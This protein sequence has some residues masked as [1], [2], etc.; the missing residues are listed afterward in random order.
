MKKAIHVGIT[1]GAGQ[2]CYS[3]LTRI[4][5]G[6]MLG[7]DQPIILHILEVSSAL[8]ALKGLVMELYDCAFPLLEG[9]HCGSDAEAL[10]EEVE[11][12][13]LVGAKPRGKGMERSDL[14]QANAKI[15][16]DQA[17]ALDRKSVKV[18]VVGNPANTNALV[19]YH[20]MKN[21]RP[22]NIRS[23]MRLDQNRAIAQLAI[24]SHV[25][26]K[27]V[28]KVAVFGN[29]SP[30]MVIDYHNA[31][32][33][34]KRGKDV[35]QNIDWL[36]REFMEMVQKRGAAIIE[37]RGSSSAT[38]ASHAVIM[39][40]RDWF[41]E[42]PKDDWYTAG[43]YTKG[44]PYGIDEDLFFSFPIRNNHIVPGL[45]F[46]EF[47]AKKIKETEAEL[48]VERDAVRAYL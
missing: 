29:H 46:D 41:F 26:V 25:P 37:A 38:S 13:I 10:F 33:R 27:E 19:L 2:I 24:K 31:T 21:Q 5:A 8:G 14:L 3:L 20:N 23:M 45:E 43:I 42:T 39:S 22:E 15:F 6:E 40:I 48:I 16:V 30:T 9:I 28:K 7:A 36:Q 17:K 18:L 47:L 11:I 4:A 32:I 1:G 12:A 44:N 35:I 34:G